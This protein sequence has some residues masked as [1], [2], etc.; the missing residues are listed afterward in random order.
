MRLPARCQGL[1]I[2]FEGALSLELYTHGERYFC[3][4]SPEIP[5]DP[6]GQGPQLS[7]RAERPDSP[8]IS[9]FGTQLRKLIK[10]RPLLRISK[11]ARALFFE[12]G[13]PD[14]LVLIFGSRG[15]ITIIRAG[16]T[17]LGDRSQSLPQ[18]ALQDRAEISLDSLEFRAEE[19]DKDAPLFA[20][21]SSDLQRLLVREIKRSEKKLRAIERDADRITEAA[22]LRL[23]AET[24]LIHRHALPARPGGPLSLE[25]AAGEPIAIELS[26][27]DSLDHAIDSRFHRAKRLERG[28]SI[29]RGRAD[30]ERERL[31]A[32]VSLR[33]RIPSMSAEELEREIEAR[34]TQ[35]SSSKAARQPGART[36]YRAFESSDAFTIFV[37]R[38]ARDNDQLTMKLA[39]PHDLFFHLRG[40]P[41]SHIIVR[42]D[43]QQVPDQT[44]I[45]AATLA[46]HFS[47]F[48]KE[49][50]AEIQ[51]TERRY[52]RKPRGSA[53]GAVRLLREKT[54]LIQREPERIRR[55]LATERR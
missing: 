16:R 8:P 24:L 1:T 54:I 55:L 34:Q 50:S 39:R 31:S 5:R 21:R 29:A 4:V 51:Y 33:D 10:G 11:A 18:N 35:R 49:A 26:P 20:L 44:I 52:I 25:S 48:A 6:G 32:L 15:N 42:T 14:E 23:E 19:F 43:K 7:L 41:G 13:G 47:T 27:Q 53:D 3:V 28:Y 37:G 46:L 22:R 45:D 9:A 30:D 2:P 38:S 40:A 12:F 17:I 36:P